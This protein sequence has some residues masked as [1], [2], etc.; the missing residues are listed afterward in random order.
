[1]AGGSFELIM[2]MSMV[3]SFIVLYV[4]ARVLVEFSVVTRLVKSGVIIAYDYAI[5]FC[6]AGGINISRRT[7]PFN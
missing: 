4:L 7:T 5:K 3:Y 2:E 1:M 6:Q